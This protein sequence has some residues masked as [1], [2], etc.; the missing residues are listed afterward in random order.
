MATARQTGTPPYDVAVIG[1][2]PAGLSAAI[3]LARYL[4]SVI[5]VD[6]GRPRNWETLA[7]HGYLGLPAA[8]PADLRASGRDACRALGAALLD[9]VVLRLEREDDETF[10]V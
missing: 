2:G 8:R 6:S 4:H 10:A 5:V 9:G 1:G 7:I 3:W